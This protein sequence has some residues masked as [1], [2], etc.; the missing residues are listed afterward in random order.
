[1]D[2]LNFH[3]ESSV[4]KN[5]DPRFWNPQISWRYCKVVLGYHIDGWHLVKSLLIVLITITIILYRPF[6]NPAVDLL[7]YG[8]LWNLSFNTFFKILN[9]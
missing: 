9:N 4:F 1:M 2:T 6:I 8:I 5:K 3:F 7:A